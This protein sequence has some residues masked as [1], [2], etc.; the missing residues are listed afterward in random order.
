MDMAE[1][2]K[3]VSK[4]V[5]SKKKV[6]SGKTVAEKRKALSESEPVA[7]VETIKEPVVDQVP[8]GN[9]SMDRHGLDE[10]HVTENTPETETIEVEPDKPISSRDRALVSRRVL[11]EQ[12]R[13]DWRSGKDLLKAAAEATKKDLK[14]VKAVAESEIEVIKEQV[15]K[16]VSQE[17]SPLHAGKQAADKALSAGRSWAKRGLSQAM[18]VAGKIRDKIKK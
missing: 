6:V 17:D 1:S 15:S 10:F 8:V 2:K 12:L 13:S 7:N 11:L 14:L 4:K 3:K 9:L 18:E 5:T 16:S